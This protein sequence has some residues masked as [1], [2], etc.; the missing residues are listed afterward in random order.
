[1]ANT[2]WLIHLDG[3]EYTITANIH[4]L[5]CKTSLYI[6]DTPIKLRKLTWEERM[7]ARFDLP[8]GFNGYEGRLI[9]M[10]TRTELV[11]ENIYLK[12][13]ETYEKPVSV[14][15]WWVLVFMALCIA[16]TTLITRSLLAM[17]VG[18]VGA[19][20]C[21]RLCWSPFRKTGKSILF[22]LLAYIG[23]WIGIFLVA[24]LLGLI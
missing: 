8:F 9:H 12:S 6:N 22:C 4:Q 15:P 1:M 13:G 16:S 5:H 11:L 19:F 3:R 23:T 24:F 18:I 10:G 17:A 21:L 2:S 7:L 20:C 14:L